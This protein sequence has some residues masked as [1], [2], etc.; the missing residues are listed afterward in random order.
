MKNPQMIIDL[1]A[2]FICRR[3]AMLK[4]IT[5]DLALETFLGSKTYETLADTET[6]LCFEM[7][8]A[9]YEMFLDEVGEVDELQTVN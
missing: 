5:Q 9:V 7:A 8:E 4:G 3:Y 1:H 6:G 2:E